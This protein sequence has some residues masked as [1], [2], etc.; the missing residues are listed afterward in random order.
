LVAVAFGNGTFV[1]VG[2][3]TTNAAVSTSTDGVSWT[4]QTNTIGRVLTDVA[5]GAST[6]VAVGA[7]GMI[8]TAADTAVGT[9]TTRTSGTTDGFNSVIYSGSSFYACTSNDVYSSTNGVTWTKITLT[10]GGLIAIASAPQAATTTS[11]VATTG[12][13]SYVVVTTGNTERVTAS[14]PYTSFSGSLLTSTTAGGWGFAG[15]GDVTVLMDG[16]ALGKGIAYDANAIVWVT[17]INGGSS[18][19]DTSFALNPPS[20]SIAL[21]TS[22]LGTTGLSS[23]VSTFSF[24]NRKV[25][26]N[27]YV[28]P[29]TSATVYSTTTG[30]LTT[31]NT[32]THGITSYAQYDIAYGLPSGSTTPVYVSTGST[33]AVFN[34]AYSGNFN[35]G[36]LTASV[37]NGGGGTSTTSGRGYSVAYGNGYFV[38][39]GGQANSA[40]A[41]P[42]IW[43]SSTGTTWTQLTVAGGGLPSGLSTQTLLCSAYG[44]SK[45]VA[46]GT[47]GMILSSN[48]TGTTWTAATSGVT[49]P[50]FR[51]TYWN[52]A[53]WALTTDGRLLTS[54]TGTGTWTVI[55]PTH[56]DT[57]HSSNFTMFELA[58]Y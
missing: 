41:G 19:S 37:T 21:Q 38:S 33:S 34:A 49:V 53:F 35:T 31:A 11:S 17:T 30:T 54:S 42:H 14:S 58:T 16:T 25:I 32:Y 10:A 4:T 36:W 50:I 18:W 51:L 7:N 1:A 39:V 45:F 8:T 3:A 9:W 57:A 2:G 46:A 44:A 27:N 26:N 29:G 47:G 43:N 55:N 48:A 24:G 15:V 22:L 13:S 52:N 20:T 12:I 28:F 5:Y 40:I 6:F 23:S 56:A